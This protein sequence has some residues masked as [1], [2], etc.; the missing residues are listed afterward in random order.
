MVVLDDTGGE[1][2]KFQ[3]R[4]GEADLTDLMSGGATIEVDASVEALPAAEDGKPTG[5]AVNSF[6]AP[7]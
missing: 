5:A 4:F 6:K 7:K 1:I 2:S 3:K